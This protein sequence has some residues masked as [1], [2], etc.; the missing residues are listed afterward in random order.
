MTL[1]VLLILLAGG[2]RQSYQTLIGSAWYP[3]VR[4]F[5]L[6]GLWPVGLASLTAYQI[7]C[8]VRL[9]HDL[10]EGP[11]RRSGYRRVFRVAGTIGLAG[12]VGLLAL[13]AGFMT[14]HYDPPAFARLNASVLG[15]YAGLL[16]IMTTLGAIHCYR[17]M[18]VEA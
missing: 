8:F 9:R 15:P 1:L 10:V 14:M 12:F 13:A 3:M 5:E 11:A 16:W 7:T 18:E 2:V 4:W 6:A 17:R